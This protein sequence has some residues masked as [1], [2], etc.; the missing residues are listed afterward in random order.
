MK[1]DEQMIK[2]LI[3][4]RDLHNI[5]LNRRNAFLR[6]A[7]KA[8]VPICGAAAVIFTI[9]AIQGNLFNGKNGIIIDLVGNNGVTPEATHEDTQEQ[10][11][12]FT[13]DIAGEMVSNDILITDT[14]W[15]SEPPSAP[16]ITD[17][18][19][20]LSGNDKVKLSVNS[21]GQICDKKENI[22]NYFERKNSLELD[23]YRIEGGASKSEDAEPEFNHFVFDDTVY[24]YMEDVNYD[25]D[26]YIQKG[27]VSISDDTLKKD[28]TVFICEWDDSLAGIISKGRFITFCS[29][30][31]NTV[32]INEMLE[33]LTYDDLKVIT[34][35]IAEGSISA[36]DFNGFQR[37][38][39]GGGV[40]KMS[41]VDENNKYILTLTV[42]EDSNTVKSL[43]LS[44]VIERSASEYFIDLVNEYDCLDGFL[45]G[46]YNDRI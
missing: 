11:N 18:A 7:L 24:Y 30:L 23:F 20:D 8:V 1:S 9:L 19:D 2:S 16:A 10:K 35:K 29:F 22:L 42:D 25:N 14:Y 40:Q 36:D 44:L 41:Y 39:I 31:P 17:L 15:Q 27:T 43:I 33:S 34:D 45:N 21:E 3:E 12:I 26:N 6:G 13:T 28:Y 38:S 46:V 5:K 37:R 4:R 32:D